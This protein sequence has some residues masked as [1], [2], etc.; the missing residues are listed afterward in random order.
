MISIKKHYFLLLSNVTDPNQQH[1]GAAKP[2]VT[3]KTIQRSD[4]T[5]LLLQDLLSLGLQKN[6]ALYDFILLEKSFFFP[7]A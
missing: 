3:W 6:S 1:R 2:K 5:H 4:K 7:P